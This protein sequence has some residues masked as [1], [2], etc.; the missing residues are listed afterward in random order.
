MGAGIWLLLRFR[1]G[2]VEQIFPRPE[3]VTGRDKDGAI[4]GAKYKGWHLLI[5]APGVEL[6]GQKTTSSFIADPSALPKAEEEKLHARE[7]APA[8]D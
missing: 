4:F 5:F 8:T 3:V 7:L 2:L 1:P 6:L